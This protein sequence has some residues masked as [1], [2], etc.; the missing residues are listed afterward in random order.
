MARPGSSVASRRWSVEGQPV[1][2]QQRAVG[3]DDAAAAATWGHVGGG[4][5]MWFGQVQK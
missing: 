1:T 3:R 4:R 2:R 5:A